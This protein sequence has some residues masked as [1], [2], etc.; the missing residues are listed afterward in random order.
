MSQKVREPVE[1]EN[2]RIG[3]RAHVEE[4]AGDE[5]E[6]PHAN[7]RADPFAEIEDQLVDGQVEQVAPDG[8]Q[9]DDHQGP[10]QTRVGLLGDCKGGGDKR[11]RGNE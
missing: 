9:H 10:Q 2:G 6:L 11:G 5:G 7:G 8:H 3:R 1:V 4:N